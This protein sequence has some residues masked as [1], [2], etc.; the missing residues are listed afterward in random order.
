LGFEREHPAQLAA[1]ENADR[2]AGANHG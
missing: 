1:A 2:S